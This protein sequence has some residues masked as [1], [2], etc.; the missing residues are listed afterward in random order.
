MKVFFLENV[1]HVGKKG[2]IKEVSSG[3]ATNFLFPKKLAKPFTDE[4]EARLK[5]ENR[6][7]EEDR[8]MLLGEKEK[9]L[10]DLKGTKLV[11][12]L[13]ATEHGKVYGSITEKEIATLLNKKYHL[14]LTKKHIQLHSGTFKTL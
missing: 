6:R 9:I 3:Y 10:E 13:P 14:P 7:K 12:S 5:K 1:L 11:F 2:D 8:R 4:L